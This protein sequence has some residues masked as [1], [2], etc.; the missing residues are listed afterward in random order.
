MSVL[1]K[2]MKMPKNCQE[3][4]WRKTDISNSDYCKLTNRDV[5]Y[6][7]KFPDSCPLIEVPE[8]HGRLIDADEL[9]KEYK[10][11]SDWLDAKQ[12]LYDV[13]GIWANIDCA[14]TI[15]Q[16]SAKNEVKE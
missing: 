14:P 5:P 15:I 8:P 10:Q 2:D 11:P 6:L 9:R 13:T 1:I 4:R 12:R 3:C 7:V 16:E